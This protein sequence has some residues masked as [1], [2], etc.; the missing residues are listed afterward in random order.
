MSRRPILFSEVAKPLRN[1]WQRFAIGGLVGVSL[2]LMISD[3]AGVATIKQF[4]S[5]V[6]DIMGIFLEVGTQSTSII[7]NNLDTLKQISNLKNELNRLKTE[8]QLLSDWKHKAGALASQNEAL[9]KLHNFIPLPVADPIS[10]RVIAS[11]G[12][13]FTKSVLINIGKINGAEIGQAVISGVALIGVIVETGNNFSRVLLITD[14]NSQVPVRIQNTG[15]PGILMGDNSKMASLFFLPQ[16][17]AISEG[18]IVVTSGG[19]GVLPPD[20]PI[21]IVRR[22]SGALFDVEPFEDWS[23]LSYIKVLNYKFDGAILAK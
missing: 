9:R 2:F 8:N 12:G 4:K 7:R 1:L 5:S 15:D 13:V 23:N 20:L 19:G 21:G 14:L 11:S 10:G 3:Q 18:D 17:S 16:N 22:G 6:L